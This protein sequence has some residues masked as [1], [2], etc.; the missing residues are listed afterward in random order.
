MSSLEKSLQLV[1]EFN[2]LVHR[3]L[4]FESQGLEPAIWAFVVVDS[5]RLGRT[6]AK[7]IGKNPSP[8]FVSLGG[9]GLLLG[10]PADNPWIEAVNLQVYLLSSSRPQN[11]WNQLRSIPL[12]YCQA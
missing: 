11:R 10:K 8:N 6:R 2:R 7:I 1:S 12:V 4:R 3:P 9:V 5:L